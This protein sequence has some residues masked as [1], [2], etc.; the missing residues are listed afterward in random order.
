MVLWFGMI[1]NLSHHIYSRAQL[2]IKD[3]YSISSLVDHLQW[4]KK[5]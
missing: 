1:D 5:L 2:R 3:A 4:I